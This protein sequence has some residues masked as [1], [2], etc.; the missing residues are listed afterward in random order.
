[1]KISQHSCKILTKLVSSVFIPSIISAL[2]LA[3]NNITSSRKINYHKSEIVL[4]AFSTSSDK[5]VGSVLAIQNKIGLCE[6]PRSFFFY[7]KYNS[8]KIHYP[9]SEDKYKSIHTEVTNLVYEVNVRWNGKKCD[10]ARS[11][12]FRAH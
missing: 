10:K 2:A 6:Y 8:K 3:Y 7:S 1:M 4:T 11:H 9:Q 12:I 5:L